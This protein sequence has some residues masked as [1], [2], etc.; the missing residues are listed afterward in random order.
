MIMRAID[1]V[2][3]KRV[4]CCLRTLDIYQLVLVI[5]HNGAALGRQTLFHT[6]QACLAPWHWVAQLL[7][8]A[9]RARHGQHAQ[10]AILLQEAMCGGGRLYVVCVQG[11]DLWRGDSGCVATAWH[12]EESPNQDE[13]REGN[14]ANDVAG[15]HPHTPPLLCHCPCDSCI[16]T[17]NIG[18]V[19]LQQT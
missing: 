11:P 9:P 17:F 5:E 1:E 18:H 14:M 7:I 8:C 12:T 3:H 4:A 13:S 6:A 16:A 10:R 2:A 15:C 19:F